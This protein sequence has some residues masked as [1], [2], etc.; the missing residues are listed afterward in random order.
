[1]ITSVFKK[2]TP[3]NYILV[4]I[5]L[6][7]FFFLFHFQETEW[8]QSAIAIGKVLTVISTLFASLF[9]VNFIVKKN[10]LTK[11]SS[12][13][14]LFFLLFFLFF[15]SLFSDVKLMLSNF[16]ILLA[17][18]RQ[19]SLQTL[20]MPKE[21]IFDASL[22][23]FIASL[24]HFWSILFILLVYV[25]I[26]FHVSRDYRNWLL[27]F[28]AFFTIGTIF[29]FCSLLFN[30]ELLDYYLTNTE[31]NY[32]ID[33]FSNNNQN[34][35]FSTYVTY[36]VFY[37]FS[38]FLLLGNR[39]MNLQASYKK[40]IFAFFVGIAVFLISQNKKSEMLVYTFFPLSVMATNIVEQSKDKVKQEIILFIAIIT[41]FICF[42]SQ[43]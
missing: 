41:S 18:R 14:I 42:F 4:G 23:I 24:F 31:T 33:Y 11:D 22:W 20:K 30:K 26:I 5:L 12:Y 43:L 3:I 39:P 28:F 36:S 17:L 6:V 35:I 9:I 34:I 1:M 13:S 21:K 16:F 10:G 32:Q 38:M 40:V 25:S 19:V 2:S 37:V 29:V 15:P 8:T 27:P 7:F